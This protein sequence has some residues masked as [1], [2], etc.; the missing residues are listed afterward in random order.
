[1]T[2]I[3]K[4]AAID[5]TTEATEKF[6]KNNELFFVKRLSNGHFKFIGSNREVLETSTCQYFERSEN[7]NVVITTRNSTIHI[8]PVIEDIEWVKVMSRSGYGSADVQYLNGRTAAEIAAKLSYGA[9]KRGYRLNSYKDITVH[10]EHGNH[11]LCSFSKGSFGNG[12]Y[13]YLCCIIKIDNYKYI[14]KSATIE[15]SGDI[16]T[17]EI[18][19]AGSPNQINKK[20]KAIFA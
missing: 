20:I 10:P 6:F 11:V 19:L 13:K 9:I 17:K 4:L 18:S 1:M 15:F 7:G 12:D 14:G 16:P 8:F 5:T 2:K 3:Y